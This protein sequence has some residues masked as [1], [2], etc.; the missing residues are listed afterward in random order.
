MTPLTRPASPPTNRSGCGVR[1][2]PA[3]LDLARQQIGLRRGR[4]RTVTLRDD[5]DD[6]RRHQHRPAAMRPRR[7]GCDGV[8]IC[9]TMTAGGDSSTTGSSVQADIDHSE[10]SLGAAGQGAGRRQQQR[11]PE[12]RRATSRASSRSRAGQIMSGDRSARLWPRG[13]RSTNQHRDRD[14]AGRAGEIAERADRRVGERLGAVYGHGIAER[15]EIVPVKPEQM[16]RQH[17][18]AD[19]DGDPG[20]GASGNKR[21]GVGRSARRR[22]DPASRNTDQY[23]PSMQ[24]AAPRP[25]SAA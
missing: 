21:R 22:P 18:E 15:R 10:V 9:L 3:A 14:V 6:G 19:S 23:L 16:R 2:V 11:R 1:R 13:R 17:G 5:G 7:Q 25:A 4:R 12:C 20:R 24:P 8:S